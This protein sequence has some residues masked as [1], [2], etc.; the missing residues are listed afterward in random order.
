MEMAAAVPVLSPDVTADIDVQQILNSGTNKINKVA[1][2]SDGNRAFAINYIEKT[3]SQIV[4]TDLKSGS[5]LGIPQNIQ[6]VSTDIY[7]F[8]KVDIFDLLVVGN[9][10]YVAVFINNSS[11]DKQYKI[12]CYDVTAPGMIIPKESGNIDLDYYPLKLSDG[13]DDKLYIQCTSSY[14][15]NVDISN[16]DSP[17][18]LNR[19]T[20][21]GSIS[22][23]GNCILNRAVLICIFSIS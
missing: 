18:P 12:L 8:A 20:D 4:E 15:Y 1:F 3:H 21:L 6:S 9:T 19:L 5:V 11:T 13:P 2:S 10:A 7:N 16:S 23:T 22:M 17:G 14:F